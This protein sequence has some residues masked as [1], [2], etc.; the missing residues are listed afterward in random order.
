MLLELYKRNID[1]IQD[2]I[3]SFKTVKLPPSQWA[4]QNVILPREVTTHAGKLDYN[5]SPYTREVIDCMDPRSSV[6]SAA[7][8]KCIQSGFTDTV[9]VPLLCYTIVEDPAPSLFASG[10]DDLVRDTVNQKLDPVVHASDIQKYLIK[11]VVKKGNHKSPDTDTYKEFRGGSIKGITYK[12]NKL[13]MFSVKKIIA[14]ELDNAKFVDKDEG[15][16]ITLLENRASS[17]GGKK[18]TL[19]ISSPTIKGR[20]NI[21][22]VY[23]RGDKRLW[24]WKCP[25]CNQYFPVLWKVDREDG[26]FGGMKW[27]YD[28]EGIVIPESIHYECQLCTG[29]IQHREKYNLNLSGKWIPTCK[30]KRKEYRSYKLNALVLPPGNTSWEELVSLW[31]EACP[32][33]QPVNQDFLKP[34]INTRLGDLWEEK[35]REIKANAL[36]NNHRAYE[37]GVVPDVLSNDKGSGKIALITLVCDLGGVM[38]EGNEDVRVD[39]E[40][41]A[42]TTNGQTYRIEHGSIGT[43]KNERQKNAKDKDSDNSRLKMTYRH[44]H[45]NSVWPE[46]QKLIDRELIGQDGVVYNVDLTLID[47]A[48]FTHLAYDF[49]KGLN[50]P[51]VVGT[52]GLGEDDVRKLDRDTPIIKRSQ[53]LKGQLYLLQ[54]NQI[55]DLLASNMGLTVGIDGY[56]P[57]GFMNFPVASGGRYQYDTYFRHYEA[58]KRVPIMNGSVEVGYQWKKKHSTVQNHFFDIAVYTLAAPEIFID[59]LKLHSKNKSKYANFTWGDWCLGFE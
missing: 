22:Y 34:F 13:R 15:N 29:K 23:N 30:P 19:Y 20:S 36:Q 55:K 33:N 38:Q 2:N 44:G 8:M 46:V 21:E 16:V 47:T 53:E 54:V 42:H 7:V 31:L 56:Q 49:I 17:Y 14:D 35:G 27:E 18:K 48:H 26:S 9:V 59:V 58:E 10:D 50:N 4:E 11:N 5:L 32:P 52:R 25:H 37:V 51:F 1:T 57:N 41:V 3:F 45:P 28:A 24:N 40:F 43:F 6:E 12:A 39:Y